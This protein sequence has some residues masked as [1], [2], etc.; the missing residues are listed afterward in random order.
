MTRKTLLGGAVVA[1][2]GFAGL[3]RPRGSEAESLSCILTPE[4][5][6]G[7]YYIAGEKLRRNIT[8]GHP[9][10]PML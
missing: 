6:E 7:P 3:E 5:T 1:A 8:D 10:A 9:G 4:Q 2:L